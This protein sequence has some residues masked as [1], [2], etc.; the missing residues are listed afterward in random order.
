MTTR[1]NLLFGTPAAAIFAAP[2]IARVVGGGAA[3]VTE[4]A[5]LKSRMITQLTRELGDADTADRLTANLFDAVFDWHYP[6]IRAQ[7]ANS[8]V[9]YSFGDRLRPG[10]TQ[11]DAVHLEEQ[12][13]FEPGPVNARLADAVHV[14][15]GNRAIPVYAQWEIAQVLASTYRMADVIAIHSDRNARGETVYLSTEGVAKAVVAHAGSA[16]ALGKAAIVGHRDHVKRCI[17]VS[18]HAGIDA[19]AA[20]DVTLPVAYDA[21]SAQPWTRRRDLYLLGDILAQ[22]TMKRSRLLDELGA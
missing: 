15:R 1:R 6:T 19:A 7:Q 12:D 13:V 18:N 10:R 22:L 21:Q 20:Q 16:E 3:P 2:A 4:E 11:A 8:I 17:L 5:T 14:I 9:A